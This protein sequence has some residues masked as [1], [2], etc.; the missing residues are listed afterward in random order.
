MHVYRWDLDRTYLDTDIHSVR[1]LIRTAFETAADKRTLPGAPALMRALSEHDASSKVFILSGSPTQMRDVLREKLA[2]DGVRVDRL[3]LKDNLGN[4]RRGRLR[5]VRGQV[6]YKLPALLQQRAG[7]GPAVRETL[8]GDDSEVDAVIYATYAEAVSRR[9]D[10]QTLARVMELG[11]AYPDAIAAAVAALP[12][13]GTADAVEDIF[14]HL[15]RRTPP[16][17]FAP[18]GPLVVPV[19][20]WF[21]AA[22]VLHRRGRLEAADL[23][24]IGEACATEGHLDEI[25]LAGLVQDAVRR[26]LVSAETVLETF[27]SH[28]ALTPLRDAVLLAVERLGQAPPPGPPALVDLLGWLRARDR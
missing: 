18:L 23:A 1:G 11:G 17:R 13:V 21:Q 28:D 22:L 26:R 6:G 20:S 19:F 27:E 7:L 3:T 25:G 10:E 12:R 8:F 4:L 14:I 24:R 15:D 9:I 16:G 2:L 5:A